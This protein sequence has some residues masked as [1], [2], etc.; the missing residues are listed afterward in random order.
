MGVAVV[1]LRVRGRAAAESDELGGTIDIE[2]HAIVLE[3]LDGALAIPE[4]HVDEREVVPVRLEL[5]ALRV[6]DEHRLAGRTQ[7][8]AGRLAARAVAHRRELARGIRRAETCEDRKSTCLNSS[9][10]AIS[11][12]VFCL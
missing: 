4:L 7:R 10:V 9:H 6:Q 5:H 8:R 11:Y 12:A 2:P 1:A 3:H